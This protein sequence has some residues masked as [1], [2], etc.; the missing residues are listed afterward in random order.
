MSGNFQM[1]RLV[2]LSRKKSS[3]HIKKKL[4]QK[5]KNYENSFLQYRNMYLIVGEC[6]SFVIG[7]IGVL[8]FLNAILT[9]I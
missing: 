9:S 6:L 3:K 5:K 7:L 8:N 2:K 1:P 4:T